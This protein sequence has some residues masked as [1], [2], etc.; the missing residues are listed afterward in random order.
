MSVCKMQE[1]AKYSIRQNAQCIEFLSRATMLS[2]MVVLVV[3]MMIGAVNSTPIVNTYNRQ[4]V[5]SAFNRLSLITSTIPAQS[6]S[7]DKEFV[8]FCVSNAYQ[9]IY[10]T[11]DK[12]RGKI[13]IG[14][15]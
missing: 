1:G 14:V 6:G 2:F 4:L 8:Y 5:K 12:Y 11:C 10:C 15:D 3:V 13:P 7:T 9:S